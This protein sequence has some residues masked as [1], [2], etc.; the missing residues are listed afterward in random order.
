L[1]CP[2]TSV[3]KHQV[4]IFAPGLLKLLRPEEF[5]HPR[6]HPPARG[7]FG[8]KYRF[9]LLEG[10]R[11]VVVYYD[12]LVLVGLYLV[13]GYPESSNLFGAVL[14]LDLSLF[15]RLDR[16]RQDEYVNP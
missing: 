1:P 4:I 7:L 13:E 14:P 8:D 16:R 5:G 12:V 9:E 11:K 3:F 10:R 2:V 15:A 6:H